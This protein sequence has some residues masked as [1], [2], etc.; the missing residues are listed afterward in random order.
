MTYTKLSGLTLSIGLAVGAVALSPLSAS[1]QAPRTNSMMDTVIA[2]G[3]NND[4]DEMSWNLRR[5]DKGMIRGVVWYTGGAGVSNAMGQAEP[6]GKFTIKLNSIYGSG[7]VGAVTGVRN[8][9]GS[10]D[11]EFVGTSCKTGMMHI[12]PGQT[13]G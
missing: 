3:P 13:S 8:K 11:A 7:P 12:K 1:A 4:C 9:D 6:D 5:D 10:T 2:A